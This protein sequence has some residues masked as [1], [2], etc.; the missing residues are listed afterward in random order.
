MPAYSRREQYAEWFLRGLQLGDTLRT[1]FLRERNGEGVGYRD[2]A[3]LFRAE[4]FNAGDWADQFR[5]AGAR[6]VMLTSKHHDGFRLWPSR[7]A[8]G[9]PSVDTGPRRDVVGELTN[10]VRAAGLRMGPYYSLPETPVGGGAW[11]G[12]LIRPEP[13]RAAG[14][15]P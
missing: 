5:R 2:F 1:R 6:Y 12:P 4:S 3:P 10:A 7:H 9:W 11:T 15:I 14:S 13:Q 8:P